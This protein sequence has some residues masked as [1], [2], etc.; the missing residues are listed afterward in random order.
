MADFPGKVSTQTSSQEP[1]R[2]YGIPWSVDIDFIKGIPGILLL[3]EIVSWKTCQLHF[4]CF[5]IQSVFYSAFEN[6]IF[7]P[8][9]THTHFSMLFLHSL[10]IMLGFQY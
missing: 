4:P 7:L 3:A 6:Y 1:Q 2:S 9:Y 5:I 10:E 8:S